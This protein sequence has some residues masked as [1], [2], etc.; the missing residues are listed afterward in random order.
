LV[1][2]AFA[3]TED[4]A[5]RWTDRFA[6]AAFWPVFG[7]ALARAEEAALFDLPVEEAEAL[8]DLTARAEEGA[9]LLG[10][11]PFRA[12]LSGLMTLERATCDAE[13]FFERAG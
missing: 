9:L 1:D 13:A 12:A 6:A 3:R 8:F 4:A 11:A 5:T 10:A 2:L 7:R